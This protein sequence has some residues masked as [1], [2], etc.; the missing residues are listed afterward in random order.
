MINELCY[1]GVTRSAE[2]DTVGATSSTGRTG[3]LPKFELTVIAQSF[4]YLIFVALI[5]G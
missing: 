1:A 3:M 2:D 4:N 5:F